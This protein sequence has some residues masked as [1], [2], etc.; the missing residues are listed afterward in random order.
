M[1]YIDENG[2]YLEADSIHGSFMNG[3]DHQGVAKLES[4]CYGY[5]STTVNEFQ[6]L[7]L[8][9]YRLPQRALSVI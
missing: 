9:F 6:G 1:K 5:F 7:V 3:Y 2:T 4:Y 8:S